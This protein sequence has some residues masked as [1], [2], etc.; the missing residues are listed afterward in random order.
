[1]CCGGGCSRMC[2]CVVATRV[3]RGQVLRRPQVMQTVGSIERQRAHPPGSNSSQSQSNCKSAGQSHPVN[4]LSTLESLPCVRNRLT[5]FL[6]HHRPGSDTFIS[7]IASLPTNSAL[8]A[9]KITVVPVNFVDARWSYCF[10][11][12]YPIGP[13]IPI[14]RLVPQHLFHWALVHYRADSLLRT[15][16]SP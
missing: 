4:T 11:L 12:Q 1:M 7:G 10:F 5:H 16:N 6:Q 9:P 13:K 3:R 14:P 2:E 15:G 8:P